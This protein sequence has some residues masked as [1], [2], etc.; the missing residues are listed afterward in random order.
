MSTNPLKSKVLE[1]VESRKDWTPKQHVDHANAN[2]DEVNQ[3][4]LKEGLSPVHWVWRNNQLALE[5]R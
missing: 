1:P 2:I 5:H 3:D 4:R